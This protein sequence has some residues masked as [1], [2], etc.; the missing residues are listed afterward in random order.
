[1]ILKKQITPETPVNLFILGSFIVG[2]FALYQ[3]FAP[4]LEMVKVNSSVIQNHS[5][6]IHSLKDT[7][8][9]YNQHILKISSSLSRIEGKLEK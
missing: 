9:V 3:V 4:Y 7:H 8:K 1:M 2:L 5:E 6:I